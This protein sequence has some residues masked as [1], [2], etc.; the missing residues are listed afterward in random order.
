MSAK[1]SLFTILTLL[2]F[3][4]VMT[5]MTAHAQTYD[6]NYACSDNPY[7]NLPACSNYYDYSYDYPDWG[8]YPF[9]GFDEYS[10][11]ITGTSTG[12]KPQGFRQGSPWFR[13][14]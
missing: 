3:G 9:F 14:R 10:T 4:I 1:I 12:S 6:N 8:Y 5:A 7:D 2:S 11:T 13:S